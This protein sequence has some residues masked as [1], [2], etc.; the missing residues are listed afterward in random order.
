MWEWAAVGESHALLCT[1]TV[2][3]AETQQSLLNLYGS[4][5][6]SAVMSVLCEKEVMLE[7]G[8]F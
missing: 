3:P 2:H 1:V 5:C 6:P 8:I 4:R 7:G